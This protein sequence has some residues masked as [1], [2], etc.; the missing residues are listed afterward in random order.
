MKHLAALI[1]LVVFDLFLVYLL[2]QFFHQLLPISWLWFIPSLL[3]FGGLW[4]ILMMFGYSGATSWILERSKNKKNTAWITPTY[5]GVTAIVFWI[6]D[7]QFIP[8]WSNYSRLDASR[9]FAKQVG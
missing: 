6:M 3:V 9:F 5:F 1:V 4:A 8:F 2:N 7:I